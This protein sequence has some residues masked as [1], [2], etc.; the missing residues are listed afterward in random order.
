MTKR[1]KKDQTFQIWC[2][3]L[4][5]K[6]RSGYLRAQA[7]RSCFTTFQ[8]ANKPAFMSSFF[9]LFSTI[10]NKSII[11]QKVFLVYLPHT[12][13]LYYILPL[14]IYLLLWIYIYPHFWVISC[15]ES[16]YFP[17]NRY[18]QRNQQPSFIADHFHSLDQ[19][20]NFLF[21]WFLYLFIYSWWSKV[22][23]NS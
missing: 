1:P 19:V 13:G 4:K 23:M 20:S 5:A 21:S 22:V 16:R 6:L 17:M 12:Q 18:N 15:G 3:V 8:D 7:K 14:L 9:F 10:S 2:R 11:L